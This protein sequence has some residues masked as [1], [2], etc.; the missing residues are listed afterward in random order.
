M[1][2]EKGAN[3]M[4]ALYGAVSVANR[5]DIFIATNVEVKTGSGVDSCC[6]HGPPGRHVTSFI[7]CPLHDTG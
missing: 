1:A 7:F 5:Q 2:R 6:F 4:H 3:D